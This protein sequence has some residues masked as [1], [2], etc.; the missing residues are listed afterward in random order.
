MTVINP[1]IIVFNPGST[2]TKVGVFSHCDTPE[3][4]GELDE[5]TVRHQESDFGE[6]RLVS[7]Q[8]DARLA[9]VLPK[10]EDFISSGNVIAVIGRG[11][12]LRPLRGG[13]YAINDAMLADFRTCKYSNHASNLGALMAYHVAQK[14]S[15]P[16]YIADP[17]TTD[18]FIPVARISGVP[19]IERKCRAHALNMKAVARKAAE[20]LDIEYGESR[21]VVA[22]MGGGISVGALVGGAIHD[23]NDALL[24]MGPFSPERAGAL[25]LAGVIKM[26]YSGEYTREALERKFSKESGLKGYLGTADLQDVERMVRQG[27]EQAKLIY[28]AMVY[29]IA[30]ETGAMTAALD[31]RIDA[32]ILT[33]GMAHSD[34]L[35]EDLI[36]KVERFGRVLVYPGEGELEALALAACRAVNGLEEVLEY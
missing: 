31:G 29:Q 17:I 23:V 34:Q 33:G 1:L 18:E 11:G 19:E 7:E 8:L 5:W 9:A 36:H 10:L 16:A 12:P 4:C 14:L 32:I 21:F 35:G 15:V 24:G 20:K 3:G 2:S 6:W 25:P 27:D 28:Q 22:H 30:K 13:V 26:A